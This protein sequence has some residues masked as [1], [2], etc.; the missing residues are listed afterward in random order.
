MGRCLIAR[1]DYAAAEP[2]VL[3]SFAALRKSSSA[4]PSRVRNALERII[5][6][7]EAWGKP[8]KAAAWREQR[9]DL[10]FPSDPF[11]R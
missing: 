6:L 1:G 4:V 5:D 7:Y 11:A 2:L 9:L 3:D 8:E 10:A